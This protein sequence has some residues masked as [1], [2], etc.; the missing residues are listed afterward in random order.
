MVSRERGQ[1]AIYT[2][3]PISIAITS[4][5]IVRPRL[6]GK[7]TGCCYV[8]LV[9]IRDD[10]A[11]VS[12]PDYVRLNAVAERRPACFRTRDLTGYGVITL[13]TS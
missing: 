11:L 3:S 10:P 1:H 7:S 4:P 13:D 12:Y 6:G 2:V 5:W 8:E 9:Q